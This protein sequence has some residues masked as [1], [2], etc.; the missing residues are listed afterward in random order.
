MKA[1]KAILCYQVKAFSLLELSLVLVIM[2]VVLQSSIPL[3]HHWIQEK[4]HEKTLA[5]ETVIFKALGA[6]VSRHKHL[7]CPSLNSEEGKSPHTCL[8]N[9]SGF[10]PFHTLGLS[11]DMS[12]DGYGK[13]FTYVVDPQLTHPDIA[14]IASK[15]TLF[16]ETLQTETQTSQND[17]EDAFFKK[18]AFNPLCFCDQPLSSIDLVTQDNAL[19]FPS[20]AV[21]LIT[22]GMK[23]KALDVN[24]DPS[25]RY[26]IPV[27]KSSQDDRVSWITRDQLVAQYTCHVCE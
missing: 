7:P 6:Y 18:E 20:I 9:H 26:T 22:H 1:L 17:A 4:K 24:K 15:K 21:I 2:G 5:H 16:K 12:K 14:Y 19:T 11:Q 10:L 13:Y 23:H 25:P 8:L 27:S 3:Y